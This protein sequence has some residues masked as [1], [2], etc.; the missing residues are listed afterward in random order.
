M[1]A[2]L[3]CN[4][5]PNQRA[6]ANLL[7]ARVPLA[8]IARV[9]PAP[10]K[11]RAGLLHRAKL[12]A[13]SLPLRRAWQS[14]QAHYQRLHPEWPA[15]PISDHRGVNSS[16]VLELI[17]SMAPELVIVSGTDL[18]KQ[19]L[20][21]RASRHGR[22][23]NL[24]TGISPYIRGGPNCTNWCLATGKPELIGN[25]VMWIDKGI[26]SGNIIATEQSPLRGVATLTELQVAVMDHAHDLL[27]RTVERL[28]QGVPLPSVPQRELGK[29]RLFLT[30]H[31][32][33]REAL[34]AWRNFRRLAPLSTAA[35]NQ[36]LVQLE[37]RP[38]AS[39]SG[40]RGPALASG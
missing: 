14:M 6:L 2:I 5:S 28:A 11:F 1:K 27:G 21:D 18:L 12:L 40:E 33:G 9:V 35:C 3:L 34:R 24:H 36:V 26:D 10:G 13:M 20:I 17:D 38:N 8:A 29:G 25:T 23:V 15:V 37:A 22:V 16:S 39:P 19:E 7:H 30:R 31:W 32:T 4:D